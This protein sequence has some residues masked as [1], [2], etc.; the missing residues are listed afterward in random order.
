MP[1]SRRNGIAHAGPRCRDNMG[2]FLVAF[3]RVDG[4][5]ASRR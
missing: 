4:A 2:T 1:A 5:G 3:V